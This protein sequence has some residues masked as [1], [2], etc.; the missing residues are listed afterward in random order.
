MDTKNNGVENTIRPARRREVR[1]IRAIEEAAQ[2]MFLDSDHPDAADLDPIPLRRLRRQV[3]AGWLLVAVDAD[4][5]PVGF[6]ACSLIDGDVFVEEVDVL[7]AFAGHRIGA[8]LLDAVAAAAAARSFE[9]VVLTTFKDVPW[10][11]P[12]YLRLGFRILEPEAWGP[13][14]VD[15]IEEEEDELGLDRDLRVCLVRNVAD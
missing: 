3:K 9:R 15:R 8:R 11:A 7:P 13:E 2:Q 4:D 6:A 12:Y 14:L 10:N 5:E 1:K